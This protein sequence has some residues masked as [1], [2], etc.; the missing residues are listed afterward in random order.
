MQ[1][2]GNYSKNGEPRHNPQNTSDMPRG[3]GG[4][5]ENMR[6][7]IN[8]NTIQNSNPNTSRARTQFSRPN[9]NSRQFGQ[10]GETDLIRQNEMLARERRAKHAE[11]LRRKERIKR[12]KIKKIKRL[13]RGWAIN[14]SR[15]FIKLPGK[16]SRSFARASFMSAAF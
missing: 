2:D 6:R 11:V 15:A 3:Y 14:S 12:A 1:N 16:H 5:P 13:V 8:I 7:D 10:T 4:N 9:G